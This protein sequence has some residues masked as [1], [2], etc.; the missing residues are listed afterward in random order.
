VKSGYILPLDGLR[1]IAILL[2]LVFHLDHGLLPG[3]F[4]GVDI[5]FVISGF[6]ITR[7]ILAQR[8]EGIFSFAEFYKRRLVRLFPASAVTVMLTIFGATLI[9][10]PE[11]V[12]GVGRT[13]LYALLSV[14]NIWFWLKSGY[15]DDV[16]SQNPLLHMWSLSVEEQYYLLWPALLAFVS[17]FPVRKTLLLGFIFLVGLAGAWWWASIDPT[18]AFYMMPARIFQFAI[19]AALATVAH[20]PSELI[21]GIS[22][23]VGFVLIGISAALA[24]GEQYNFFIAAVVQTFGA[25]F[26]IFGLQNKMGEV[27]LGNIGMRAIGLRAYSIYLVHW[28]IAVFAGTLMGPNRSFT[29]NLALFAICLIAGDVLYRMV[30]KPL[31]LP[32]RAPDTERDFS[33]LRVSATLLLLVGG[34]AASAHVWALNTPGMTT[35]SV[36]VANVS[37]ENTTPSDA[38]GRFWAHVA[39]ESIAAQTGRLWKERGE[40]SKQRWGC[41][42]A[43]K[44][45]YSD[46]P[47][48]IC[49][50]AGSKGPKYLIVGDSLSTE[51]Q[52]ALESVIPAD[53]MAMAATSGC[54]PEY[55]EPG[56]DSRPAGCQQLNI[57]RFEWIASGEFS[58]V[59]LTANWRW[60]NK[61]RFATMLEYLKEQNV[62]IVVMGPRPAYSEDVPGILSS[63]AGKQAADDLEPY[64]SY[65]FRERSKEIQQ[66]LASSGIEY[67]YVPWGEMLCPD[68]CRAYLPDGELAYLDKIHIPPGVSRWLG[69]QISSQ[70]G[71]KIKQMLEL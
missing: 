56:W 17:L 30:E 52:V 68:V 41:Q 39:K 71:A 53:R 40:A 63:I 8:E 66:A 27:L 64:F 48:D 50:L 19:G 13:A 32:S 20:R 26:A 29:A 22:L 35:Q 5:F 33:A 25:G 1:A 21:G 42:L 4:I 24:N 12:A 6:I 70:Y 54:L 51:A 55:P 7:N 46:F 65:D 3:G 23:T 18:G 57:R 34:L 14:A 11:S 47:E 38:A 9:Y 37:G 67:V 44:A 45:P 61:D 2:V 28:P 36:T 60:I 15:F 10:G 31:R 58:G 43:H 59:I 62:P 16:S 49:L 69:R